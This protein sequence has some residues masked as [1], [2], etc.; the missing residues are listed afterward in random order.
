MPTILTINSGSSSLKLGLYRADT[1]S[2][3]PQLL[4][5]GATDAIGKS[6]GSL[7]ITDSSG[8]AIH[9][10]DAS[11]D[12]QS[13]AFA[14]AAQKLQQLSGAQPEAIGYRIVHGGPDLRQHCR[15]TP[16]VL[17][18]L[19]AA[20]HYAPL[21]IPPA[22]ALIDTA[23][24]L[25]P[26]VPT[27]ACFD[28]AFHTTMPPE[29]YTY[30]IPARFREQGVQRYGFH[31]LSYESVVAALAPT[32]PARLVVA[33]L[34]NGASLCAIAGGRSVDTS[35][36]LTP[37][38]GIPMGTRS[39]DLDPGVVLFLARSGHLNPNELESVLNHES[40]L[41]G[42]SQSGGA[43]SG[44]ANVPGI[45]DLRE[46]TAA[47]DH[48]SATAHQALAIFCRAIAK[49]AASYA[50]VLGGLDCLVF[51][52]GIGEHSVLVR[53]Q[54]SRQLAFLG[55]AID[56]EANQRHAPVISKSA[57]PISVRILVADED[58]RIAHHVRALLTQ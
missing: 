6:G 56:A 38:G 44:G 57:S 33:H 23:P 55:L 21:H 31:G 7:T 2:A 19:R 58:G 35:M 40:G 29:A 46:L 32:V 18:T 25:Y 51:T 20:V 36:G 53:E 10:E 4:Y 9:H 24:K 8:K 39:G 22:L 52:G 12:S 41:A 27:F 45:S 15:I 26:Q 1:G 14:H 16:Q 5:R 47:A 49:T 28:T 54:V 48:G 37:T 42:L 3:E 34:G 30:A 17:D 50:A 43:P 13:S 11:H